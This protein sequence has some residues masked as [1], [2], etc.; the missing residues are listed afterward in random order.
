MFSR[1]PGFAK[2][3]C[4]TAGYRMIKSIAFSEKNNDELMIFE[5]EG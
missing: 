1:N 4:N 3:Y 2:K 5:H